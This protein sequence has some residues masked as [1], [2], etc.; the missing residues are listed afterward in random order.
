MWW[1]WPAVI[2]KS[3][4]ADLGGGVH[5]ATLDEYGR[6]RQPNEA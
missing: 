6:F 2:L 4:M 5:Y 3:M 1:V